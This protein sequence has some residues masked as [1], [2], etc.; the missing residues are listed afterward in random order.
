MYRYVQHVKVTALAN[1]HQGRAQRCRGGAFTSGKGHDMNNTMRSLW[2]S[3][4]K[5]YVCYTSNIMQ[6]IHIVVI[7][8]SMILI[9]NTMIRHM[10]PVDHQYCLFWRKVYAVTSALARWTCLGCPWLRALDLR[11]KLHSCLLST[12]CFSSCTS[13]LQG[14]KAKLSKE[15]YRSWVAKE[16]EREGRLWL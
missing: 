11:L 8:C 13:R 5:Y 14:Q 15:R 12:S 16:R 3:T 2:Y 4:S 1:G 9:Y 10:I 6:C 7:F